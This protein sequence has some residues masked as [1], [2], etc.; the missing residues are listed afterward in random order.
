MSKS[1]ALLVLLVV[2]P[3]S[4]R[5]RPPPPPPCPAPPPPPLPS[6]HIKVISVASCI[7]TT[8]VLSQLPVPTY[9]TT[10][11]GTS[12]FVQNGGTRDLRLYCDGALPAN[13][14]ALDYVELEFFAPNVVPYV[15]PW[16]AAFVDTEQVG[17]DGT[18]YAYSLPLG[19]CPT[20][21]PAPAHAGNLAITTC[22]AT[23]NQAFAPDAGVF[24]GSGVW[25]PIL[26]F[27]VHFI[28]IIPPTT[29][30]EAPML[31]YRLIVH[32]E[33]P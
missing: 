13:A 17:P 14:T 2:T 20:P 32:Y 22:Q 33:S 4:S 16:V 8:D 23:A 18:L 3:A 25:G 7:P 6:E 5:P 10:A 30:G 12:A 9:G 26:N 27:S 1:L 19:L 24:A 15:N 29:A 28:V 31:A 11:D 21:T